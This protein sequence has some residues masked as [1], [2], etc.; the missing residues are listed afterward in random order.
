MLRSGVEQAV[1][2][3]PSRT[4]VAPNVA[5]RGPTLLPQRPK[6]AVAAMRPENGTVKAREPAH[7]DASN[8][9]DVQRSQAPPD[10]KPFRARKG[11]SQCQRPTSSLRSTLR[12]SL[13]ERQISRSRWC[14]PRS[15]RYDGCTPGL[16][17]IPSPRFDREARVGF[18]QEKRARHHL[19]VE[20]DPAVVGAE[21]PAPC[22]RLFV[23]L[24]GREVEQVVA[25]RRDHGADVREVGMSVVRRNGLLAYLELVAPYELRSAGTRM[26]GE[27]VGD[28]LHIEMNV[29]VRDVP[30]AG[31]H[32]TAG[33]PIE[34]HP[35]ERDV[36]APGHS[37][38]QRDGGLKGIVA[39]DDAIL[40]SIETMMS[41]GP[42]GQPIQRGR[43]QHDADRRRPIVSVQLG[44]AGHRPLSE[45][46]TPS[47]NTGGGRIGTSTDRRTANQGGGR[48]S[49]NEGEQG[50]CYDPTCH[51]RSSFL[52]IT[53]DY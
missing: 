43:G 19:L 34:E 33:V 36:R 17:K 11:H 30:D 18:A 21:D 23:E 42:G 45:I 3:K 37:V 49:E 13:P 9:A 2:R 6:R 25:H 50:P 4:I 8:R 46:G 14:A 38:R 48:A 31:R 12:G 15:S 41:I 20:G 44:V 52:A 10:P 16:G 29:E 35:L 32:M 39:Y 40:L 27:H 26:D 47:E 28:R 51:L 24:R 22:E 5:G 1:A 7:V 53:K